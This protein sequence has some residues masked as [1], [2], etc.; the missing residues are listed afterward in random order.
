MA[1]L[2]S[3]SIYNLLAG[4]EFSIGSFPIV[5]FLIMLVADFQ[6]SQHDLVGLLLPWLLLS[7]TLT[8]I[9]E[10]AAT[11]MPFYITATANGFCVLMLTLPVVAWSRRRELES[12]FFI[13]F[14]K[15][16]WRIFLKLLPVILVEMQGILYAALPSS[17]L[18]DTGGFDRFLA[19]L[20]SG[21]LLRN[22]FREIINGQT[23]KRLTLRMYLLTMWRRIPVPV[24][25]WLGWAGLAAVTTLTI[26]TILEDAEVVAILLAVG[27]FLF[28]SGHAIYLFR[29]RRDQTGELFWYWLVIS[30]T[31]FY[32]AGAST[33]VLISNEDAATLT[34]VA[35]V[36]L[37]NLYRIVKVWSEQTMLVSCYWLIVT[38]SVFL[39]A[40][41]DGTDTMPAGLAFLVMLVS[42]TFWLLR[43]KRLHPAEAAMYWLQV[44][45]GATVSLTMTFESL[46]IRFF[47]LTDDA[48]GL[49]I[50]IVATF[51]SSA[52]LLGRV[53]K[54]E[55]GLAVGFYWIGFMLSLFVLVIFGG[56]EMGWYRGDAIPV[57]GT[58][59]VVAS[60]LLL[61]MMRYALLT[62]SEVAIYA[63]G[64]CFSVFG[65]FSLSGYDA[66]SGIIISS[67]VSLAIGYG[68]FHWWV[69]GRL[70]EREGAATE[71]EDPPEV[72]AEPLSEAAAARK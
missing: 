9:T 52:L 66:E 29:K 19:L 10:L 49:L 41:I 72:T 56:E 58:I 1:L 6:R 68:V 7:M 63:L 48:T 70:R 33:S 37:V 36:I 31:V 30:V 60:A 55:S 27:S 65:F 67:A 43:R 40:A 51:V 34:A 59:G 2:I 38:A 28:I 23:A 45:A 8:L 71:I 69:F 26:A 18:G 54:S 21:F 15:Q 20:F 4:I 50:G 57:I 64:F 44:C 53:R 42:I 17:A 12:G 3:V 22:Q 47:G 39:A 62:A 5:L 14:G 35:A 25:A 24:K 13:Y 11:G 61:G 32:V 46:D 16:S